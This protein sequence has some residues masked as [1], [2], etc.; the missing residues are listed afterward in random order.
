MPVTLPFGRPL[1]FSHV[2][3]LLSV[4]DHDRRSALQRQASEEGWDHEAL[5]AA[6]RRER[7]PVSRGGRRPSRPPKVSSRAQADRGEDRRLVTPVR[8]GVGRELPLRG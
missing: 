4:A 6:I 2:R 5:S 1:T 7:A 3:V 8:A